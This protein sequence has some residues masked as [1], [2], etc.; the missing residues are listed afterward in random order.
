MK[1]YIY[2]SKKKFLLIKLVVLLFVLYFAGDIFKEYY[3]T[4]DYIR[5]NA[6]IIDRWEWG[7]GKSGSTRK[8]LEVE[9]IVDGKTYNTKFNTN[10]FSGKKVGKDITIYC[11]PYDPEDIRDEFGIETSKKLIIFPLVCFILLNIGKPEYV[12]K[13]IKHGSKDYSES[14]LTSEEENGV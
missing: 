4:K 3:R 10:S 8:E 5:V 14:K 1:A 6:T 11:N 13:P 7:T 9:Y 2:V 12:E